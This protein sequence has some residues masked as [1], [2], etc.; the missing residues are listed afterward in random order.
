MNKIQT[1]PIQ[2]RTK[3]KYPII[4]CHTAKQNHC[5]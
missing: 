4:L 3:I 2:K 1:W 5:K